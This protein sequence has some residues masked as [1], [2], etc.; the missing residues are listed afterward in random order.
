MPGTVRSPVKGRCSIWST[1]SV[2]VMLCIEVE[3]RTLAREDQPDSRR[4]LRQFRWAYGLALNMGEPPFGRHR[5]PDIRTQAD[6]T[7]DRCRFAASAA[8]VSYCRCSHSS[9]RL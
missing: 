7:V 3:C 1:N 9:V 8:A 5:G 2:W 6:V 4:R